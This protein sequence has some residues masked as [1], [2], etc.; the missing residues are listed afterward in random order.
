MLNANDLARRI[1]RALLA[2]HKLVA[3]MGK[4]AAPGTAYTLT[5]PDGS[6]IIVRGDMAPIVPPSAHDAVRETVERVWLR[7]SGLR[8]TAAA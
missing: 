1:A 7:V 8:R 3:G 6:E 2:E 4:G 5:L